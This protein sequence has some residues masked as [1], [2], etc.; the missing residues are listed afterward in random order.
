M[1]YEMNFGSVEAEVQY[2]VNKGSIAVLA[3]SN[4]SH[5][6]PFIQNV[7]LSFNSKQVC[8]DANMSCFL[9][10]RFR[11]VWGKRASFLSKH[12]TNSSLYL[13]FKQNDLTKSFHSERNFNKR[14]SERVLIDVS[15][16]KEKLL[17]NVFWN[18][19]SKLGWF[20]PG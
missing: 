6:Y 10:G 17:S 15:P 3:F 20:V 8:K 13:D 4:S 19:P 2:T 16:V 18:R 1:S 9:Y 5:W 11:V 14:N 7:I 12:G